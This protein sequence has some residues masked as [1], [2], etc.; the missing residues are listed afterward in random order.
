M[1]AVVFE[2]VAA[3][4]LE[5]DADAPALHPFDI[6]LR[7]LARQERVFGKILEVAAVVRVALDVDPGREEDIDAAVITLVGERLAR[8]AGKRRVPGVGEQLHGGEGDGGDGRPF[9]PIFAHGAQADR[10]VGDE[11]LRQLAAEVFGVPG[12]FAADEAQLL[13]CGQFLQCLHVGISPFFFLLYR[14]SAPFASAPP[15][16][17]FRK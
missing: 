3:E 14:K 11:D 8:A 4:V 7:H 9:A 13:L 10:P 16:F 6:A 2:V 17:S 5:A 12:V 1:Q 15:K